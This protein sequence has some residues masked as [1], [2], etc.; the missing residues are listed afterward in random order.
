MLG[1]GLGI[2]SGKRTL[3][4]ALSAIFRS[5]GRDGALYTSLQSSLDQVSTG[6]TP[7]TAVTNPV[8]LQLDQHLGMALGAELVD[9][10]NTA[11]A[12]TAYA[13]NTVEQD[14][15]AVKVT[16]VDNSI[17]AYVYLSAAGGLSANLV[18]GATYRIP[19]QIKVNGGSV[20]ARINSVAIVGVAVTSTTYISQEFIFVATSATLDK[21]EFSGLAAGE[22]VWIKNISVKLLEGNHSL[23]ATAAARP[24]WQVDANGKYYL[25]F[26]GTDDCFTSATGGGGSAGFF[27][28]GAVTPTG[29]AGTNTVLFDDSG[30]NT[31][32][33]TQIVSDNKFYLSGGNGTAYTSAV[34]GSTLSVGTTYLLTAWDDG[35][36]LNVQINAGAVV[37]IARPVIVAG[38]VGYKRGKR[39]GAASSYFIGN[40]YASVYWK[41]TAGTA[42]ERAIAQAFIRSQ[43]GL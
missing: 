17:G 18:V 38:T 42:A 26:L 22:I 33:I 32:Y 14:G 20:S 8:G 9:T 40:E 29:G 23:Q 36:N 35:V 5:D 21:L 34:T 7:V 16:H 12:W 15:D 11:A 3:L 41:N 37:S 2:H 6:T 43:A 1:I 27:W 13:T 30:T 25:S 28:C 10:M 39:N 19:Y 4:T 31:G 24:T